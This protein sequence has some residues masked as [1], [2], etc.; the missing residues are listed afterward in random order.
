MIVVSNTTP[1]HYLILIEQIHLLHELYDRVVVP[2]AVFDEMQRA[3]TPA[4]V[5]A[6]VANRPAW[7]EV[8]A[9]GAPDVTLNLGAGEREAITLALDLGAELILLDDGKA[10]RAALARGLTV[11][12][13]LA[14][15]AA[16]AAREL[17]DLPTALTRLEQTNFRIPASLVQLLLDED[18]KRKQGRGSEGS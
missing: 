15:L 6:F 16:A 1:I 7:L 5:R 13:T 2:Q 9:V 8:Q 14:V 3:E 18:R 17:V 4:E 10:R 12:G 11:T